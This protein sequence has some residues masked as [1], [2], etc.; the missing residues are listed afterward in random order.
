[1]KLKQLIH[2]IINLDKQINSDIQLID[3]LEDSGHAEFERT[4]Q[5]ENRINT[6]IDIQQKLIRKLAEKVIKIYTGYHLS[7]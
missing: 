6:N 1:M 5:Y 7:D 4:E 2:E 3:V